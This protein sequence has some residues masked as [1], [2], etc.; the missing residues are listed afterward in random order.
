MRRTSMS[1]YAIPIAGCGI[2]ARRLWQI[3]TGRK[4]NAASSATRRSKEMRFL[5]FAIEHYRQAKG[6]TGPEV[7]ALFRE[8]GLSQYV[9]DNYFLYHIESPDLM[10]A[11]IDRYVETG[12]RPTL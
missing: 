3:C 11:D 8:K 5:V 7:A 6:L 1:C 12:E 4:W 10:V 9:L 2:L